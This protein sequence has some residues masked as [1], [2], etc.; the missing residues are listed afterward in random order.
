MP[1]GGKGRGGRGGVGGV[2]EFGVDLGN[3]GNEGEG[4]KEKEGKEGKEKE[5]EKG[6]EEKTYLIASRERESCSSLILSTFVV[7]SKEAIRYDT[8]LKY[9]CTLSPQ[10][11]AKANE[12]EKT[13]ILAS[14]SFVARVSCRRVKGAF[15]PPSRISTP[16]CYARY[17]MIQRPSPSI[18]DASL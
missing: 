2:L 9:C 11:L 1:A 4:E 12:Y 10:S 14:L 6:K 15:Y 18:R 13:D 3:D 16:P 8:Q 17:E 7:M 5:K